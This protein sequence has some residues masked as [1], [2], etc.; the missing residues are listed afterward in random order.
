MRLKNVLMLAVMLLSLSSY[1]QKQEFIITGFIVDAEN[2]NE[3]LPSVQL[4]LFDKDST[5]VATSTT[6]DNGYFS[7]KPKKEGIYSLKASFIGYETLS[8]RVQL[9][10]KKPTAKMGHILLAPDRIML[11]EA[12]V[13]GLAQE[14]TIKADTFVYHA[15]AYRVPKGASIAALVKQLPGLSMD[16]DGNL[17]FQGKTVGSILVNGKPF[18]GDANTAMSN[19]ASDAVSD[20]KV[21]EKTDEDKEF[22]GMHDNEKKTVLDLKI[23]KEYMTS[24]NVNATA[25]A[26]THNRYMGKAFASNFTDKRLT[27]VYVQANN[28]SEDQT[29]DENGNWQFWG[30]GYG[31]FTYRRSGI[32]MS[33]ENGLKNTEAKHLKSN[34]DITIRHNDSD[35][36]TIKSGEQFLGNGAQYYYGNSNS[37]SCQRGITAS[38]KITYN[39]DTLNRIT[40]SLNYSYNDNASDEK[41]NNSV[42]SSE[43]PSHDAF[44]KLLAENIT[45]EQAADGVY[46][47]RGFSQDNKRVINLNSAVEYIHKTKSGKITYT[48]SLIGYIESTRAN[49]DILFHYRYFNPDATRA[50]VTDRRHGLAPSNGYD[51][52]AETGIYIKTGK[53]SNLG[54]SYSYQHKTHDATSH[55]YRLDRYPMYTD[56]HLPL[57]TRPSTADSLQ[58]VKDIENSYNY[59]IKTNSHIFSA[60]WGGNWDKLEFN[61]QGTFE[62]ITKQLHYTGGGN[63]YSPSQSNISVFLYSYGKWKFSKNGT[64]NMYHYTYNRN[65]DIMDKIPLA[66]TSNN[67]AVI[68]RNPDLKTAWNYHLRLGGNWFND[69]RG[70]NYAFHTLINLMP[71]KVVN[72]LRTDPVSGMT[73]QSKENVNGCYTLSLRASTEQP[74]DSARHWSVN[75]NAGSNFTRNKTFIGSTGD[76][77]GLSIVRTYNPGANIQLKWRKDI[78]N[79]SLLGNYMIEKTRYENHPQYNQDGEIIEWNFQP[80]V[81]FPFG[82]TINTSF[83]LYK[84]VGYEDD[85]L[86]HEQWLWNATISQSLLKNKALTLQ[87][88]A[89]DILRQ[90]TAEYSGTSPSSRDF[91]RTKTFNSYVMLNAIWRFNVG[92]KK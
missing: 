2:I 43:Q 49:N 51:I 11:K 15:N 65:P 48:T 12:Q 21:Y 19:M 45:P 9:T 40:A 10:Q 16:K 6:D 20:I 39:I 69:K 82:M 44:D 89:V 37:Y 56:W 17:T 31:L 88:Q 8:K 54:I 73:I 57:G 66:N 52:R 80:Q 46:S 3:K 34:L 68:E 92:G 1:A 78:W 38:G 14:L 27:A 29:V 7:I 33:W 35:Y 55:L 63:K 72:T 64:I 60:H 85:L 81:D 47:M 67:M 84:R 26:G 59:T 90:R 50:S 91:S 13:T 32:I 74:L 75:V 77:M 23:K 24:W 25:G 36:S 42:F 86:N 62:N 83:G 30:H 70:D 53:N 28:I 22:Q 87:L 4:R 18:F 76:A 5:L 79:I 71:N 58:A 41:K 61:M